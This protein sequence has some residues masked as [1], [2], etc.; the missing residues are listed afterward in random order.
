MCSYE[1]SS[2]SGSL[3]IPQATRR[4]GESAMLKPKVGEGS[5]SHK[6]TFTG[7]P[8]ASGIQHPLQLLKLLTQQH[9]ATDLVFLDL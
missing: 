2:V 9:E 7:N 4:H 1:S 8:C 6:Q 5:S 3:F